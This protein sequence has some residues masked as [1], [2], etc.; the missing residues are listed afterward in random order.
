MKGEYDIVKYISDVSHSVYDPTSTYGDPEQKF[1]LH[2]VSI[3]ESRIE[4]LQNSFKTF[5]LVE[6]LV[7]ICDIESYHEM[8]SM[9]SWFSGR[10]WK[11]DCLELDIVLCKVSVRPEYAETEYCKR[12]ADTAI[13]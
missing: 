7:F 12:W 3:R 4:I 10:D 11:K 2:H 5:A 6:W 1:P 8:C 13:W 9:N